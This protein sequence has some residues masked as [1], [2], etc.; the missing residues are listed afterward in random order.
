MHQKPWLTAL[1]S[2]LG[3][4]L[5]AAGCSRGV[6]AD[7]GGESLSTPPAPTAHPAPASGA[8][9]SGVATSP[10]YRMS[11]SLGGAVTPMRSESYQSN[12]GGAQ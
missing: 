9:V 10:S 8:A 7:D 4:V 1:T 2:L 11:F 12:R 5:L 6:A 3:V